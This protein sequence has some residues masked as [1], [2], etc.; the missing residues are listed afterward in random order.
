MQPKGDEFSQKE[1]NDDDNDDDIENDLSEV[2]IFTSRLA[3]HLATM[4]LLSNR[5]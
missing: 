1:E 4:I 3:K 2:N 5:N